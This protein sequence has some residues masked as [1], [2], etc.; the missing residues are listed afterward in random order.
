[1]RRVEIAGVTVRTGGR[2]AAALSDVS[3]TFEAGASYVVVGPSGAGKSTLLGVVAGLVPVARGQVRV[4]GRPVTRRGPAVRRVGY[5]PQEDVAQP[6]LTVFD[7]LAISLRGRIARAA[8][9][10]RV[11][12]VAEVLGLVGRLRERIS[13]E[14]SLDL[15]QRVSLGRA[16]ARHEPTAVLLDDPWAALD[17]SERAVLRRDV[18]LHIGARRLT[19]VV[20]LPSWRSGI[21]LDSRVLVLVGGRILREGTPQQLYDTP[22][23]D[24]IA[25]LS[26]SPGMN[27]VP[28]TLRNRSAALLDARVVVPG[29]ENL[30]L[31]PAAQVRLGIRPEQLELAEPGS[32]NAVA[33]EVE[34][35]IELG[36]CQLAQLRHGSDRFVMRLRRGQCLAPGTH[37]SVRF[38]PEHTRVFVDGR[39]IR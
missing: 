15:R 14:S 38:P 22:E 1:M 37:H 35:V 2:A 27:L 3:C 6:G 4:D 8:V 7:H 39:L 31:D 29:L 23:L 24:A 12:E 9:A 20:A 13:R 33:V 25:Q 5:A 32:E 17:P 10:R 16:L 36:H 19:A 18:M 30:H 11:G 34:G 21:P 26:G 28:C